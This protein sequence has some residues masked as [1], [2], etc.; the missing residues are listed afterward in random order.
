MQKRN[1]LVM[2]CAVVAT[3]EVAAKDVQE[4]LSAA[5]T[6]SPVKLGQTWV[7]TQKLPKAKPYTAEVELKDIQPKFNKYGA[8]EFTKGNVSVYYSAKDKSMSI[9]D[10][11]M[12]EKDLDNPLYIC[13]TQ[14]EKG[15][16]KGTAFGVPYM[17]MSSQ[18]G[19][20]NEQ[21][22]HSPKLFKSYLKSQKVTYGTCTIQLK[23]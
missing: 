20:M 5:V 21:R 9:I 15:I 13:V 18:I 10:V 17:K 7:L 3:A 19:E 1:L 22:L 2:L 11:T 16:S 6:A 23:K 8:L 4:K 12:A 14:F